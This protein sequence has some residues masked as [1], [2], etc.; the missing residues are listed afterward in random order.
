MKTSERSDAN[1]A[2]SFQLA[3][4]QVE[5]AFISLRV[6]PSF[7]FR[8]LLHMEPLLPQ[9]DSKLPNETQGPTRAGT[10]GQYPGMITHSFR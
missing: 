6:R 8:V 1:V 3:E 10:P 7:A 9:G 5:A 4:N 2:R